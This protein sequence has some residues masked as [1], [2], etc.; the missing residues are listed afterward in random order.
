MKRL[1]IFVVD[2]HALLREGLRA[3]LERQPSLEVVGEAGN[4]REAVKAIEAVRPDIVLMDIAMPGLNGVEATHQIR[5]AL[6]ET[7]VLVLS[8]YDDRDDIHDL[9][10]AGAAGYVLK[11]SFAA[12]LLT[13]IDAVSRGERCLSPAIADRVVEGFVDL[14]ASS[15]QI[16]EPATLTAREREILQLV[17]GGSGTQEVARRLGIGPNIAPNLGIRGL[18]GQVG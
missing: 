18:P 6:P 13:A 1:R 10:R 4:G 12:E 14:S 7:K 17:A 16:G 3:L 8:A 5:K 2:D 11:A 9:L 15:G